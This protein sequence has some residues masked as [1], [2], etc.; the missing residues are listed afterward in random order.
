MKTLEQ[1]VV[2]WGP[3]QT[4]SGLLAGPVHLQSLLQAAESGRLSEDIKGDQW[5]YSGSGV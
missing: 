4:S 3:L 2:H 1:E 5:S